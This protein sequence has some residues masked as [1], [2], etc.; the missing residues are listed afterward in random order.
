MAWFNVLKALREA[1]GESMSG[2]AD[3]LNIAKSTYAS[4][5]YGKREPNIE[6]LTKI[7]NHYNV[8]VDYLLG[9]EPAPD[10][11]IEMLSR[12][13]NLNLYEKAIVTAY[14][15][16][17]TKSRTDLVKMVQTVADAVQSGAESKYTYTI[18]VAARGDAAKSRQEQGEDVT[19][20]TTLGAV[21]DQ[22]EETAKA[23]EEASS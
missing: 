23:K 5:E 14:L 20:S 22:M 19:V 1:S 6:M 8:T 11:P 3:A 18:Q 12:E 7:A 4:Y 15:A 2:A 13:L 17:D 9:R 10:D 21:E 16:M